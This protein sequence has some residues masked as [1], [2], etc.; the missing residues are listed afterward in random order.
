M[1][2]SPTRSGDCAGTTMRGLRRYKQLRQFLKLRSH[3]VKCG[4]SAWNKR[5]RVAAAPAIR[6]E[7]L[8]ADT[9]PTASSRVGRLGGK[10]G[11]LDLPPPRSNFSFGSVENLQKTAS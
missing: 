11:W 5:Q 9:P 1:R 10:Q 3:L 8:L 2:Q 4:R 6:E 7:G